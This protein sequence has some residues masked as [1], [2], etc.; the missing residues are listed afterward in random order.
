M[1]IFFLEQNMVVPE[2]WEKWK[3]LIALRSRTMD[4]LEQFIAFE[5]ISIHG[6]IFTRPFN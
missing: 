2:S 1:L 3:S 6:A 5:L 4:L